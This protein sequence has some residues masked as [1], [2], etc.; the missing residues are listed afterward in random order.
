MDLEG[1]RKVVEALATGLKLGEG[2]IS[3]MVEPSEQKFAT[4]SDGDENA[5]GLDRVRYIDI[6]TR[7]MPSLVLESLFRDGLLHVEGVDTQVGRELEL[8]L[9][10]T[11]G[12][13]G[14][15]YTLSFEDLAESQITPFST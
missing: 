7:A 13:R 12:D 14:S 4:R 3:A 5:A 8:K 15:T 11:S 6:I 10:S 9:L 1:R 2:E